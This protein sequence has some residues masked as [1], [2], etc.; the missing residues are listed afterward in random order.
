MHV[1]VGKAAHPFLQG[2]PRFGHLKYTIAVQ[3]CHLIVLAVLWVVLSQWNEWFWEHQNWQNLLSCRFLSWLVVKLQWIFFR[4]W[5]ICVV[6][7]SV[8]GF[9]WYLI[10]CKAC[11]KVHFSFHPDA[12]SILIGPYGYK[13]CWNVIFLLE[14]YALKTR[15]SVQ[16]SSNG[17]RQREQWP[18]SPVSLRK[19]P[20]IE[21]CLWEL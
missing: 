4:Y 1:L 16:K 17:M 13:T 8:V 9:L 18:V 21:H 20:P 5:D 10:V 11:C 15:Q 14:F 7:C 12:L 6:S 3:P 19:P 2:K